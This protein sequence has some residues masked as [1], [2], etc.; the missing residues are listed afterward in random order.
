MLVT[1]DRLELLCRLSNIQSRV[2]TQFE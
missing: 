1:T 2:M